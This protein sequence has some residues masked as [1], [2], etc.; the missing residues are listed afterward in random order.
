MVW[1]ENVFQERGYCLL[2]LSGEKVLVIGAGKSGVAA[3]RFLAHKGAKVELT[4]IKDRSEFDSDLDTLLAE[5]IKLSFGSYPC[6]EPEKYTLVMPS[7]GVPLTAP[8]VRRARELQ[9]PVIG[10]LELAYRFAHAPIVAITG[11]NGKTTTTALAGQIFKNAGFHTLVAGNI[12][13][14]LVEE[15]EKYRAGDLIIAE[16]SSFQLETTVDFKPRVGIILNITPDHLDRHLTMEGY[17]MA[18]VRIFANQNPQEY[19]IL[20]FDD[21]RT[22]NLAAACPGTVMFFSRTHTL[23]RGV[24]VQDNRIVV[25]W[26]EKLFPVLPVGELK[27]PGAHNLE[28]A[29]A[30]VAC[31]WAQGIGADVLARVLRDFTGVAHRL[32]FVAEI[33]GVRYVNDSKGT[34]PDASIKALQAYKE[35]VI[36][37][38]GGRNK[39]SDFTALARLI[40]EK[41]RAV[42]LLGE[43]A[44]EI[45]RAVRAAGGTGIFRSRELKEAILLARQAACPGDVVLLSPAC[46]SWDMFRNYEQRG[47][48]FKQVV[49]ELKE[50]SSRS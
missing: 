23:Q 45:E 17:T 30:A 13:I 46:A 27:I 12:G 16:V 11:T 33:E 20:N 7:P 42:V 1:V 3:S 21:Q 2:K 26:K 22:K 10:E 18:K 41:V 40:K 43:S 44:G 37:I 29:L 15:V 14:P 28:N 25:R 34:N 24:F 5:G 36:L 47:N 38:A 32:E 8:P 6:V 50:V 9:I 4:D 31:G 35:P 19:C 48:L 39:G 49:L